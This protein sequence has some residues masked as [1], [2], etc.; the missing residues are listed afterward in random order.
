MNL[1][2]IVSRV[3]NMTISSAGASRDAHPYTL[4]CF[5][6]FFALQNHFAP[7]GHAETDMDTSSVGSNKVRVPAAAATVATNGSVGSKSVP[8][9]STKSAPPSSS[10]LQRATALFARL[11]VL[12]ALGLETLL[13][14]SISSFLSYLFVSYTKQSLGRDAERAR[15]AGSVYARINLGSGLLQFG[16]LP[17]WFGRQRTSKSSYQDVTRYG[18]L[19]MP[20]VGAVA[21]FA[22][23]LS[24]SR[25]PATATMNILTQCFVVIKIL[26]YSLRSSLTERV[27]C[28]ALE[29]VSM[30]RLAKCTTAQRQPFSR[31]I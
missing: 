9:V 18:W 26:E 20:S 10:L 21:A 16:V 19:V 30:D 27:R 28:V 17:W 6:L 29:S 31:L 24:T 15:Y 1:C 3:R 7:T 2:S 14:Q 13:C 4:L 12:P 5:L 22:M 25:H 11:P 8:L 23:M